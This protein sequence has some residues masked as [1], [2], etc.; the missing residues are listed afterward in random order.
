VRKLAIL[1]AALLVA[2]EAGAAT[3]VL[4]GGKRLEVAAYTIGGSYVVVQYANGRRESYPLSVVDLP[5]TREASGAKATPT[6]AEPETPHSPFFG[7]KS[8]GAAGGVVVTDAD[9]Q[10]IEKATE[11]EGAEGAKEP[12]ADETGSQVTLVSYEK[13][14]V[15][16]GEWDIIA[17]VA[18]QG[19]TAVNGVSAVMRVLDDQG[20]PV[21]TGS[22]SFTGKLDPGKQGN[23]TARVSLQGEPF[24]VAVDLSWREIRTAPAPAATP[25]S[26]AAA[27]R[28]QATPAQGSA[29]KP[30]G[31][32][33]PAGSPPG[34]L[35]SNLMALPP[36]NTLGAP[37]QVPRGEPKS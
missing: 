36:P 22:G 7:A 10:H 34:T 15:G 24:Q 18:N 30:S 21:A 20:K 19:K 33:V 1:V 37:P 6:A 29:A 16:E 25:A 31:W 28:A 3:V 13:K 32:S 4:S 27:P 8:S 17:T 14:K 2:A 9:V 35:P 5:A 12:G 11:G 26:P 23:I